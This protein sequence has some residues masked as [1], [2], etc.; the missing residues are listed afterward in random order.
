MFYGC[1]G[2]TAAPELPATALTDS[3]YN[4]MFY[5]CTG[6]TAAPELPAT[7]L[8]KSCYKS[9]FNGCTGL[10]E[11]TC[12]AIEIS[13]SSCTNNW[14]QNVA[15]SGTF[16]KSADMEDWTTGASG[17]PTGWTVQDYVG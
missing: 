2:L 3:C 10:E 17:I 1:T 16:I 6:L 8:A 12:L 14:L 7:I 15:S 5:G 11:V 4:S 9:M 13:A